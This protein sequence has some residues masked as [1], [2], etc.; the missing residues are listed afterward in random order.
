MPRRPD[1][2]TLYPN[3]NQIAKWKKEA[4]G[5]D[6]S[7]SRFVI[8]M[9]ERGQSE[10]QKR[11]SSTSETS[12]SDKEELRKLR[13]ELRTKSKLIERYETELWK[14]RHREFLDH[15]EYNYTGSKF[16]SS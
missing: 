16:L 14:L 9:A 1:Y 2:I 7:L 15:D 11:L 5:C 6:L 10:N 3:A 8:E 13:D 12:P 4:E